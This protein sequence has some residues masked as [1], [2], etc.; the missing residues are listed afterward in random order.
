MVQQLTIGGGFNSQNGV[1]SVPSAFPGSSTDPNSI[2]YVLQ[3]YLLQIAESI[4][5]TGSGGANF[6]NDDIVANPTVSAIVTVAGANEEL[7]EFTNTDS[8]GGVTAGSISG[9]YTVDP[10]A[11]YL[12][13]Q[14]P[15]NISLT[16]SATTSFALFGSQSNVTYNVSNGI[17]SSIFAAGGSDVITVR[18]DGT[19]QNLLD[20]TIVSA[21]NSTIN[22]YGEGAAAVTT[23]GNDFV[24]VDQTNAT[25]DA[26]GATTVGWL[27]HNSGGTLDFVNNS[28][29]P[30]YIQAGVFANGQTDKTQVT[31]FGGVGG[32]Y[33]IGGQGGGSLPNLLV[34]GAPGSVSV[35]GTGVITQISADS[36]AGAVTLVGAVNGDILDA[37]GAGQNDFFAGSGSETLIAASTTGSNLFQ[38]GLAYPGIGAP[39]SN[40]VVSTQGAGTQSYFLGNS[41][42]ATIFGSTASTAFN[43]FNVVSGP[44]AA[45]SDVTAG[46]GTFSIF[47]FAPG[48]SSI[49]LDNYTGTTGGSASIAAGGVFQD[50]ANANI[51][52]I[53][54]TDGTTLKL[55]GVQA[56][57]IASTT[58]PSG[59]TFI[60]EK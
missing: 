28:T 54:L 30:A 33:F 58:L 24:Q 48:T 59:Q 44:I 1:V 19:A 60:F 14:A 57:N 34:G 51:A 39:Q 47:N 13:V 41:A 42:G 49:L 3:Q 37:Q 32:G 45:G 23:G 21:G 5:V 35:S 16:G 40:G 6:I 11:T 10:A 50:P 27:S 17:A 55:Y 31:A 4:S 43:V 2:N 12:A 36:T 8:S 26:T 38:L 22:L 53:E 56:S 29:V 46:G 15:G 25:V 9:S 20:D 7:E 52:E 18:D